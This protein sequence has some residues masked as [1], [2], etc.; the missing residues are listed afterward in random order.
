MPEMP[1]RAR[2]QRAAEKVAHDFMGTHASIRRVGV[3]F[4]KGVP[5]IHVISTEATPP[6]GFPQ[7]LQLNMKDGS[8]YNLRISWRSITN[9]SDRQMWE[10]AS[11]V[12]DRPVRLIQPGEGS[13]GSP[14][15][16]SSQQLPKQ[17]VPD[18]EQLYIPMRRPAFATPNFWSIPF[19]EPGSI[20][21]P[22]YATTYTAFS[23]RVQ[24]TRM[25]MVNGISY[26]F[27][28]S[29]GLFEQFQI[30]LYRNTDELCRF[31]DLKVLNAVD[32]AEQYAFAGHYRQ[33]PLY[34]RF[35]HDDLILAKVTV[36]GA[37]PFTHTPYDLLGG[38]FTVN[39]HGWMASLMD[40]RD[41]GARPW[42]LGAFNDIAL[43]E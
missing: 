38:C 33:M 6:S 26:Q 30:Q 28:N 1:D 40:E 10:G 36:L 20:C 4:E 14:A 21:V 34:C 11:P 9:P 31:I 5:S 24:S 12:T 37:Y 3:V 42:D 39:L 43:G 18:T 23:Y 8:K 27:D 29:I 22:N 19:D 7:A 25:V 15:F 13:Q 41:G 35:D 16:N 32:P 17:I 2:L